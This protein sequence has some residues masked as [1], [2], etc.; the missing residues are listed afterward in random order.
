MYNSVAK[1]TLS[2]RQTVLIIT[3]IGSSSDSEMDSILTRQIVFFSDP[4]LAY[5]N[6]SNGVVLGSMNEEVVSS[7]IK[8]LGI[9]KTAYRALISFLT[10]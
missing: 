4:N 9:L 10:I 7:G 5:S 6:I 3:R 1:Q 8:T 2:S